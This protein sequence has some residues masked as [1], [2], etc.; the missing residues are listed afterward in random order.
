MGHDTKDFRNS[1]SRTRPTQQR[2]GGR[3]TGGP[4]TQSRQVA[5]AMQVSRRTEEK[6][7]EKGMDTLEFKTGEKMKVLNGACTETCIKINLP[8]RS[9]KM[10]KQ[11]RGSFMRHQVQRNDC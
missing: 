1:S 3:S 9:G 6:E 4:S 8:V 7:D 10:G 5:C 2:S 11:K